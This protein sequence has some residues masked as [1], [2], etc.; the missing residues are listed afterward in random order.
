MIPFAYQLHYQKRK[1]C[2]VDSSSCYAFPPSGSLRQ[3]LRED[4][5]E[6]SYSKKEGPR[7]LSNWEE[8][9]S[10]EA[11]IARAAFAAAAAV[12]ADVAFAAE[13]VVGVAV[14]GGAVAG[15]EVAVDDRSVAEYAVAVEA[16]AACVVASVVAGVA[17]AEVAV[18][19][20][21]VAE[22]VVAEVAAAASFA[23]AELAAFAA[24]VVIV[25]AAAIV[26][27]RVAETAIEVEGDEVVVEKEEVLEPVRIEK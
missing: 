27:R 10:F 24:L 21:V 4:S 11:E 26:A 15:G 17:V 5:K 2:D 25:D 14:A 13:V 22:V 12:A 23:F 8:S 16:A 9:S 1:G 3:T 7:Y 19:E 20:V 6:A 18:A